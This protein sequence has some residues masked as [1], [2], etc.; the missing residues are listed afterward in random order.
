MEAPGPILV[1]DDDEAYRDLL[2]HH[3]ESLGYVILEANNGAKAFRI[4][5][6]QPVALMILDMVMPETDGLETIIRLRRQPFRP[7]ILAISG[8]RG[9]R[10][11]LEVAAHL[12]VEAK[13][14]KAKP[15]SELLATVRKLAPPAGGD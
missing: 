2:R 12:G 14:E 8:A 1:V 13:I 7:R 9:G 3:L 15:I 5:S 6:R 4:A 11:Y 10:E